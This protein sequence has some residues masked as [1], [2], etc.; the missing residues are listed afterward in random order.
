ME[1]ILQGP[2][3]PE[4]IQIARSYLREDFVQRIIVSCWQGEDVQAFAGD[5]RIEVI[6]SATPKLCGPGN[7]NLQITSS[8]AGVSALRGELAAKMRSD[9]AIA[10]SSLRMMR[11]FFLRQDTVPVEGPGPFG[12]LFTSG[13]YPQIPFHPQDHVFWGHSQDLQA[14]FSLP[15]CPDA[16]PDPERPA[17]LDYREIFRANMY[18]GAH[19]YARFDKAAARMLKEPHIYLFDEAPRR[20]E[21]L[22]LEKA[23]GEQ[24]FKVFPRVELFWHRR[25]WGSYPFELGQLCGEVWQEAPW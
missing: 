12:P 13:A 16:R 20:E 8:R 6:R 24:L 17:E 2:L 23:W 10:P 7:I 14:L 21:A 15:L 5:E 22:A 19:Y 3:V 9:Q 18:L 25:Q 1:I 11:D 4:T